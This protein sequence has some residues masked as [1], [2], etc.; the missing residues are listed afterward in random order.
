M[1]ARSRSG[2]G[3]DAVGGDGVVGVERLL[4]CA[5]AGLLA[6]EPQPR[7]RR[8]AG[9]A[10]GGDRR[11]LSLARRAVAAFDLGERLHEAVAGLRGLP[12]LP[13]RPAAYPAVTTT[14]STQT[15][16]ISGAKRFQMSFS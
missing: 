13:P 3:T 2:C 8:I 6:G 14:I 12:L 16:M 9:V 5:R 10:V 7:Q 4:L 15:P 1:R 11:E